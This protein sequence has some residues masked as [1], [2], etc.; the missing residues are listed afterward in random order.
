MEWC[1]AIDFGTTS[2]AA[3]RRVGDRVDM[4]QFHGVPRLSSMAF[5][6][7]G[8]GNGADG[9]LVIGE[10]AEEMSRLAPWCLEAT[11]KRRLGEDFI[12][13]GD[14][15]VRPVE[16]VAAVYREIYEEAVALSGGERPSELR[17]TH[18]ARWRDA[19]LG[20]L[21]QAAN[22]A[23][24]SEPTFVP[25]PVAAAMHFGH[26][27]LDDGDHVAV[28]DLGGGTLDTA[29]VRR[30]GEGFEVIGRPGGNEEF[31]G[32][33]FDEIVYRHLGEQ[34]PGETWERLRRA[35]ASRDREWSQAN[36]E[37]RRQA[38]R[39]KERL[40]RNREAEIYLGGPID[41]EL[42]A[43]APD[44]ERLISRD[45]RGSVAE[46]GVTILAAGLQPSDLRAIYL[47]GG[48]SRI[49]LVGQLI[50]RELAIK[51]E[52]LD[53]PKAVIAMGAARMSATLDRTVIDRSDEPGAASTVSAGAAAAGRVPPPPGPA[54]VQTL[55]QRPTPP[56]P[57]R[58]PPPPPRPLGTVPS[59]RSP[60]P[61]HA[62]AP[63]SIGLALALCGASLLFLVGSLLPWND[64]LGG[65]TFWLVWEDYPL[66]IV[67][68][69]IVTIL[70][71][72]VGVASR[73][74][75]RRGLAYL[76]AGTAAA[77]SWNLV[78]LPRYLVDLSRDDTSVPPD[79]SA[80]LYLISAA[81]ALT[82]MLAIW[83]SVIEYSAHR[84]S[85]AQLGRP[86]RVGVAAAVI[87]MILL[88]V[89]AALVVDE[90]NDAE[91]IFDV[92][93]VA[94]G[95]AAT[96]LLVAFKFRVQQAFL[97]IVPASMVAFWAFPAYIVGPYGLGDFDAT[98]FLYLCASVIGAIGVLLVC[99]GIGRALRAGTG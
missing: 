80:G 96:L 37:L 71:A 63:G 84:D 19:R 14:K 47:A 79:P 77:A 5:W 49:P 85:P 73:L 32:E 87:S 34:L 99:A 43:T 36:R 57:P 27:R 72:A 56:D 28:Y 16:I 76:I 33:D 98:T 17:L 60:R 62:F 64:Y 58:R 24:I 3:S 68:Q 48:S 39:I 13:L 52:H 9:R 4:V 40:S 26:E 94:L 1:L 92:T 53:D 65:R 67:V 61:A 69:V 81:S 46:L 75:Q 8:T 29:V 38:R 18:P 82:L 20:R 22:L 54:Q 15:Q 42:H 59:P 91:K 7:D 41:Q 95:T 70:P 74:A 23:G 30:R 78:D 55:P 83:M 12:Q 2:S 88:A 50:E 6:K 11:P 21:E 35:D 86:A 89:G 90:I 45:L 93:L 31:G 10:E 51:P 66:V 97:Y 44:L 25:E